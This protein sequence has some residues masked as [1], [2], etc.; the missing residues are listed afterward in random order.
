MTNETNVATDDANLAG[1]QRNNFDDNWV[2]TLCYPIF[3][4][5]KQLLILF[6][7]ITVVL[8]YMAT[9]LTI[10]AGFTKMI[11]LKHEYMQTFI[12]YME[13]FGGANK[14]LVALKKPKG[15]I[16]DKEFMDTLRKVHEDVFYV[17]GVE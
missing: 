14:I 10:Q 4:Y 16:Y 9:H 1:L 8:G 12:Q 2:G 15:E 6:T 3:R 7:L 11:P 17:K 5:R 13:T